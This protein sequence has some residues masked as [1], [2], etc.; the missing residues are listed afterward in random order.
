[1]A[2]ISF[3]VP[4]VPVAQP[5]QRATVIAGHVHNYTPRTHPV[6][7][8]KAT[9]RMAA[10]A[11]MLKGP[12]AGPIGLW[13]TFVLP[14]PKYLMFKRKPMPR[15]R[16]TAKPDLDN[17]QKSLKDALAG[18]AW[19]DDSQVC[20]GVYDKVFASGYETPHVEVEITP[21]TEL[22]LP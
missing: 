22:L 2:P 11:V 1:M 17:L 6:N 15:Q 13:V 14:R 5:R 3:S 4:A 8:F 16:H 21:L 10:Q 19:L 20:E 9:V 12:L 7:D 18:I